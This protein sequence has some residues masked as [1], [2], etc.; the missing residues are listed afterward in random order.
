MVD[1][2]IQAFVRREG[3]LY[4][5]ECVELPLRCESESLDAAIIDLETAL[6]SSLDDDDF[7]MFGFEGE[8]RLLI[9]LFFGPFGAIDD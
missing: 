8:P 4:V 1:D 5:A 6:R 9:S 7:G 3:D 2:F